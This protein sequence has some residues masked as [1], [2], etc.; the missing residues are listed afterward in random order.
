MKGLLK[1]G[2]AQCAPTGSKNTGTLWCLSN[3]WSSQGWKEMEKENAKREPNPHYRVA[4]KAEERRDNPGQKLA[5]REG[6]GKKEVF[7]R[8]LQ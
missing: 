8:G 5:G 7:H 6:R 3:R 4:Q 2:V 1:G